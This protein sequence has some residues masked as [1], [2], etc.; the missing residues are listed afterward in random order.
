MSRPAHAP[1]RTRIKIC[2]VMDVETAQVA[3][4]AGA[5]AIGLVFAP[6]STRRIDS[7][8]ALEI[9]EFLP[10]GVTAVAVFQLRSKNDPRLE[11][12]WGDWVQ[13]HGEEDEQVIASVAE[14]HRVMRG[15]PFDAGAVRRWEACDNVDALLIDGSA[16]GGGEGFDHAKLTELMPTISKPVMLAGGLTP[17]NVSTA[18][19]AVRP[20]AVD[21]SSGVECEKGVKDH[22]LIRAFCAAVRDADRAD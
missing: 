2:G 6:E 18:I 11:E 10:P 22:E 4:E 12:W 3:A 8:T 14:S 1:A 19:R 17:N 20:Y 7:E 13:L 9:T 5:D 15:F 21:V 16:G